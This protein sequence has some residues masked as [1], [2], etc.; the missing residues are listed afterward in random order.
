M[1]E[2]YRTFFGFTREPFS[3]DLKIEEILKTDTVLSVTDRVTYAI[4]LGAMAMITGEVGSGKST[5][6]RFAMS[7]FHPSEYRLLW[8]TAGSG[9]ILELYRQLAWELEVETASYSRATLTRLIRKGVLELVLGKKQKVILIVDEASLL[10]L[11]VFAELHTLAQFDG[12]SKPMLPMILAGQNNLLDKLY[13]RT[14]LPLASRIVARSHLQGV[15]R[16]G[17]EDYLVHHLRIAGLNHCPFSEQAITAIHQGSGGLFRR[18][19]HLARGALIAAASEK[20]VQVSAEHVR[21][22]STELI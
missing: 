14:S 4:R 13:W 20:C 2:T 10:R 15:T 3:S 21:L 7:R 5:C 8:I 12:D 18:A 22:A 19:N 11:E 16:Q 6:L 1:S 17:M 9:S